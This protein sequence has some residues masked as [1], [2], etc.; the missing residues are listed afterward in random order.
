[1]VLSSE[2]GTLSFST[3]C[4]AVDIALSI[5]LLRSMGFIPAATDLW[6]SLTMDCARTVAVVVPS[7]ASSE[8]CEDTCLTI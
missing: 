6:P 5:P 7:P 8:V 3:N 4:T 2:Q 1:M